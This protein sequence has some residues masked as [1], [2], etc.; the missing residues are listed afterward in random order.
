MMNS[1]ENLDWR[2]KLFV[3][4][5]PEK[6]KA[7]GW[8]TVGPKQVYDKMGNIG[9][10]KQR[11][12]GEERSLLSSVNKSN[13]TANAQSKSQAVRDAL[14][15]KHRFALYNSREEIKVWTDGKKKT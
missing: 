14:M 7:I 9:K 11:P 4:Q 15:I 10:Q 2:K 8:P 5:R 12:N 13:E 6:G 3:C 1:Q